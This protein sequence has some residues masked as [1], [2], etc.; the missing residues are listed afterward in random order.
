[1]PGGIVDSTSVNLGEISISYNAATGTYTM[2]R[3]GI[4]QS[5]SPADRVA[6]SSDADRR[7]VVATTGSSEALTLIDTSYTSDLRTRYVGLGFWQSNT[8]SGSLQNTAFD[9]FVYGF[10]T[11]TAAVPRMGS[12]QYTTDVFGLTTQVGRDPLTFAGTGPTVF[13]FDRSTFTI[14]TNLQEYYFVTGAG[15]TGALSFRAAGTLDS[16]DGRFSGTF[17]Y[18]GSL[19]PVAGQLNGRFYGPEAQEAGG[20]F[21]GDNGSGGTVV[22][23]FTAANPTAP[24]RNI[25][26]TNLNHNMGLFALGGEYSGL[27]LKDG[28]DDGTSE[29]RL[30]TKGLFYYTDGRYAISGADGA[31]VEFAA[32]DRVDGSADA[33][34]VYRKTVGGETVE[35]SLYKP[36]GPGEIELTYASFG[37]YARFKETADANEI[38]RTFLSYGLETAPG[39]L[40]GRTG[41][42]TYNGIVIGAAGSAGAQQQLAVTGTSQFQ[43]DFASQG[44]G[45]WLRLQGADRVG[46]STVDFGQFDLVVGTGLA[47]SAFLTGLT[48]SGSPVGDIYMRFFGPNGDEMAGSFGLITGGRVI[49]GATAAVRD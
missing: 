37:E 25:T 30:L 33:F 42:A 18:E 15:V 39:V 2:T 1:M 31:E 35:M 23:G 12:A 4:T 41:T 6:T 17:R 49:T 34:T 38:T 16:G 29:A 47:D 21:T 46:G 43:I 8:R 20:V 32:T 24:N 7:Y 36:D 44:Y 26:L 3:D 9:V 14:D 45:G 40:L 22:G 11:D 27:Q 13:D 19:D 10:P 28:T 5:F 48:K